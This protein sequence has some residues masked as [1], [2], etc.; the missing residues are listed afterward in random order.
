MSLREGEARDVLC[1][2]MATSAHECTSKAGR[3]Q[4]QLM[5]TVAYN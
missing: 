1:K 5:M 3:K 2:I 4:Q